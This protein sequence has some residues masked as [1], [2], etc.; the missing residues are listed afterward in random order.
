MAAA[1][2]S[3]IASLHSRIS[4]V[5]GG[6][7][8]PQKTLEGDV[9]AVFFAS[10][11]PR[12]RDVVERANGIARGWSSRARVLLVDFQEGE[13]EVKAFLEGKAVDVD[14]VLDQDGS[15]AKRHGITT[16]PSLLVLQQGS[17]A[18]RGRLPADPRSI[19]APIFD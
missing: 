12:C 7:V 18:F 6:G 3:S 17:V 4:A 13:P 8:L 14:V 19:L 11:S 2:V 15:F 1:L 9:I 5:L 10:W 16:L